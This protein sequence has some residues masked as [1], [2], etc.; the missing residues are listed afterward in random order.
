MVPAQE[1][2]SVIDRLTAKRW[3]KNDLRKLIDTIIDGETLAHAPK[4]LAK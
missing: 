4:D 2:P 1:R 3:T